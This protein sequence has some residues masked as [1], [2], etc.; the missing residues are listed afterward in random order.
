MKKAVVVSFFKSNNIGDIALSNSIQYLINNKGYELIK[1]DFVTVERIANSTDT[2]DLDT[3]VNNLGS[4]KDDKLTKTRIK[5]F[6]KVL[7]GKSNIMISKYFI[8][9]LLKKE[10]WKRFER[11]ITES[12]LLVIGGGN[13]LMDINPSWPYLFNDYSKIAKRHKKEMQVIF[14]GAGPINYEKSFS[15]YRKALNNAKKI[16]VRD[17][18]S[19]K[20]CEH[21]IQDFQI[22]ETVDP[23]FSIPINLI[24]ERML[25]VS[26]IS[27]DNE[28]KI[29]VN[30]LANICFSIESDYQ[31]YLENLK[32][33]IEYLFSI[34]NRKIKFELFSTEIA[35]YESIMTL[36]STL[37]ID[38]KCIDVKSPKSVNEVVDLYKS[39][40]YLIGGRMHGLIFAQKCLL[41]FICVI[42]QSKIRG[43]A[44]IS[45]TTDHIFT[46]DEFR[47]SKEKI[48]EIIRSEINNINHIKNM[49]RKNDELLQRV[50]IGNID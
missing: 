9:K 46:I 4:K 34:E 14:V 5:K 11:D 35:D 15:I 31:K 28:L 6:I 25:R 22:V 16:S 29:G 24:N 50:F 48:L 45:E 26:N 36:K 30:V 10:E 1:Y 47:D 42:W 44:N 21:I 32:G 37:E 2:I 12:D 3:K 17:S 19:K 23:V 38:S 7:F 13:M 33:L 41:P 18:L 49:Q 43:F 20:V 27:K 39:F 8:S 40:D